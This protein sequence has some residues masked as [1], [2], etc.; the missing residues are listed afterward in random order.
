MEWEYSW[1]RGI[2]MPLKLSKLE[3]YMTWIALCFSTFL[4]VTACIVN[5]LFSQ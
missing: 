4:S 1:Y 3:C 5:V 2:E